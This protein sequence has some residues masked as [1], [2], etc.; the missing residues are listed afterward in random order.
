LEGD[1]TVSIMQ[2]SFINISSTEG[3]GLLFN[4]YQNTKT[5]VFLLIVGSIFLNFS[6]FN[7]AYG[8][9]IYIERTEQ[10]VVIGPN[11]SCLLLLF[12]LYLFL[13]LSQHRF[14]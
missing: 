8:G 3:N 13:S 11:V 6:S 1:A 12:C 4:S 14:Y 9:I 2:S 5:D 10:P 7:S